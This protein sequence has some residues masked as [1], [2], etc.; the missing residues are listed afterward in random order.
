MKRFLIALVVFGAAVMILRRLAGLLA[1]GP[2]P[3]RR[4]GGDSR[5]RDGRATELVRDRICNTY[6]PK[7]RALSLRELGRVHFFC[8]EQ[9]RSRHIAGASSEIGV[10]RGA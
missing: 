3:E 9:C 1:G 4:E 7:D 5:R 10:A 6:V 8:S 2:P